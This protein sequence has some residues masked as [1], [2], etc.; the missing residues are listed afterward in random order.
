MKTVAIVVIV[1]VVLLVIVLAVLAGRRNKRRAALRERFGP[2]YDLAIKRGKDR[3]AV[4]QRLEQLAQQRDQLDIH[5]VPV[6]EHV[7]FARDW[8]AAQSRFVD[9]PGQAV[10]DADGLVNSV[11]RSRGYPVDSFDDRA[12]L[13]ATDHQDVVEGY[14][15]AH[16]TFATHL[17]GGSAD[18]EALRQAF[19]HYRE[20]FGRL[21]VPDGDVRDGDSRTGANQAAVAAAPSRREVEAAPAVP[22]VPPVP[23]S[24]ERADAERAYTPRGDGERATREPVFEERATRE[25]VF[26]ERAT[27]EPVFEERGTRESEGAHLANPEPATYADGQVDG[28]ADRPVQA[29]ASESDAAV[30]DARPAERQVGAHRADPA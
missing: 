16:D 7:R 20:V 30:D 27:R 3:R 13:V 29:P 24:A 28:P 21:N 1:L 25:P 19:L 8:D 15:S 11:L 12:A 22:Q 18:T 2:E 14:R 5:E 23:V 17:Q 9:D 4:E 6:Q 10:A 26:G